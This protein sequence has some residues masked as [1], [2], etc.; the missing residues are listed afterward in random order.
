MKKIALIVFVAAGLGLVSCKKAYSCNCTESYTSS[1]VTYSETDSY[2]M[3]VKKKDK[4][5]ECNK[6]ATGVYKTYDASTRTC[7][8]N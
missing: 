5:S 6:Y 8:A 3:V 1:G 4:D 2:P 7:T